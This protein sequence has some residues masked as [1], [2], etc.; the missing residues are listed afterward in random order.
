MQVKRVSVKSVVLV[1]V[2]ALMANPT[3]ATTFRGPDEVDLPPVAQR[4]IVGTWLEKIGQTTCTKGIEKV[5]AKLY[6]VLRCDDGSG[7]N[8]GNEL[9][10]VNATKF[11]PKASSRNGDYYI[12]SAT[13]ELQIY[14]KQGL[15]DVL[16]KHSALWP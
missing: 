1:G 3:N 6:L 11:R 13:G 2:V 7:G 12:V 4:Q 16:P 15:I 8:T 10:G 14:D 9:V 5:K